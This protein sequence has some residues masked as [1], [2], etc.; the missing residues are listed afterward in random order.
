[1]IIDDRLN[2]RKHVKYIG[3]KASAIQGALT[4]MMPNIGRSRSIQ[5]EDNFAGSNVDNAVYVPGLSEAL[6]GG[7]KED[8]VFS[9]LSMHD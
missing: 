8:T 6:S 9:A 2:I 1:M 3:E 5:K 7:D 4:G